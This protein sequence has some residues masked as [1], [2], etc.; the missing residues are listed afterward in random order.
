MSIAEIG[1]CQARPKPV[2]PFSRADWTIL[3]F[4]AVY[5]VLAVVLLLAT[6][7]EQAFAFQAYFPV[8]PFVFLIL[9]P[10]I[11][12]LLVLLRIVHRLDSRRGRLMAL[13]RAISHAHMRPFATGL[14]LLAG[15]MIFQGAFT[16]I[17]T[18]LP[19][20]NGGFPYDVVHADLDRILHFG[21]DP[22]RY[23]DG[24]AANEWILSLVE[25]NYNQGWFIFC[26]A[27]LF[28]V[29]VSA[30]TSAVRARYFFT[31]LLAWIIVGNIVAGLSL[32]AGPAFYGAVTGDADRFGEQLAFL[33]NSRESLHSAASMQA[34]LWSLYEAGHAGLGSG[35]SAFPSMHVSLV[36]LNALF[37]FE[38][39]RKWG[40]IGF[41]Y[42]GVIVLSSV[43]LA[44]HYAIDAYVAIVLTAA[45]YAAVRVAMQPAKLID[46][47]R[48]QMEVPSYSRG[49]R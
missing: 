36:T 10:C 34:Y 46:A 25:W 30:R 12:G 41:V 35:I 14:V 18:A 32:S 33:M 40:G 6:G 15:M 3:A 2:L 26:Y 19:L 7:A 4:I 42:V 39:S 21:R 31:Y 28:F 43:Y 47:G 29:A 17:K 20:W 45:I 22:W 13:R 49:V 16:S 8:W 48:G 5:A 9:F 23:L 24:F 44:W 11:Y 37:L 27:T 38:A 1:T